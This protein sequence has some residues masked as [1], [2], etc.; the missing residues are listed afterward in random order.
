MSKLGYRY[1]TDITSITR[2]LVNVNS[3]IYGKVYF[4]LRSN[5]LKEI[6]RFIGASWK[7]DNASGLQSL[8]CRHNWEKTGE[9][10][11]HQ[12]L[13]NY[14]EDDCRAL[15]FLADT[16]SD[17][18][19]RDDSISDIDYYIHTK[20]SRSSKVDNPLHSQLETILKF[21]HSSYSKHKIQFRKMHQ[22]NE[23][24]ETEGHKRTKHIHR[25]RNLKPT[26]RIQISHITQC[27]KCGCNALSPSKMSTE[28]FSVDLIFT[29][30]GV[31]K[32]IAQYWAY[33]G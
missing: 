7:S 28:R 14:N 27:P 31:R 24:K 12:Y 30:H 2:R 3:Y 26:K 11:Y 29:K 13:T 5:R 33:K 25:K 16:L 6:G 15:F 10:R 19:E 20:K 32:S 4:P 22:N 21:A 23:N 8:V 1:E 18:Q 9:M 17:I